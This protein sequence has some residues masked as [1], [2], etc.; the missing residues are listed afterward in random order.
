MATSVTKL[1][2]SKHPTQVLHLHLPTAEKRE[3]ILIQLNALLALKAC[4][5]AR[6]SMDKT[7]LFDEE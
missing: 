6:K 2:P 4:G 5:C 1:V 7:F 3:L